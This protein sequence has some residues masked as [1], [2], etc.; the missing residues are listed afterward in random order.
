MPRQ[1][2]PV[3]GFDHLRSYT[4]VCR[5]DGTEPADS[6][7][8]QVPVWTPSL[9]HAVFRQRCPGG[10]DQPQDCCIQLQRHSV[11]S[12]L[13]CIQRRVLRRSQIRGTN[14]EATQLHRSE[15]L[16]PASWQ[17]A[18]IQYDTTCCQALYTSFSVATCLQRCA[19][20]LNVCTVCAL[21]T[22]RTIQKR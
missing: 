2:P 7:K 11:T 13:G 10:F 3:I 8:R 6:R 14:Q 20:L 5:L 18:A 12:P 22:Y 17:L 19:T 21:L 16:P 1:A 15:P 9:S 4:F